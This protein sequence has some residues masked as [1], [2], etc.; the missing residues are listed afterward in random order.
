MDSD[1]ADE[2]ANSDGFNVSEEFELDDPDKELKSEIETDDESSPFM[3]SLMRNKMVKLD[4]A[5]AL[6]LLEGEEGCSPA[7]EPTVNKLKSLGVTTPITSFKFRRSISM[8]ERPSSIM[9]S[10]ELL[11]PVS[12]ITNFTSPVSRTQNENA[13]KAFKR[14]VPPGAEDGPSQMKKFRANEDGNVSTLKSS[15]STSNLLSR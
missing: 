6:K 5:V 10:P 7:L 4:S 14:P 1:E 2:S 11:K 8:V 13:G 3:S 9:S 12:A 15:K